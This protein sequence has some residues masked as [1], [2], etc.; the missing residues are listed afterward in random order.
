MKSWALVLVMVMAVGLVGVVDSLGASAK[1]AK[2]A[3]VNKGDGVY[4][5][6]VSVA[7]DASSLVVKQGKK[8]VT[9]KVD[10]GTQVKGAATTVAGI[11][12]GENV[13]VTLAGGVAKE[14]L[15]KAA[16]AKGAKTGKASKASKVVK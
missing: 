8:E 2:T 15:V 10:A 16:K 12:P 3:K 7:A 1:A 11:K 14:I 6:V 5:K 9:V 13:K 4:G